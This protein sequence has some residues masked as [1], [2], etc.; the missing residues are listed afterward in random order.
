VSD[1]VALERVRTG[2]PYSLSVDELACRQIAI[3]RRAGGGIAYA[4]K[5]DHSNKNLA[6]AEILSLFKRRKWPKGLSIL[7]MPGINWTFELRLLSLREGNWHRH[8]SS[9]KRTHI[10]AVELDPAIYTAATLCMPRST[11]SPI[12]TFVNSPMW[13]AHSTGSNA[14]RRFHNCD[15]YSLMEHNAHK[16][17]AA[18]L[19]FLGPLSCQKMQK[20][21]TFYEQWIGSIFIVTFLAARH[22]Q[23]VT[24]DAELNDGLEG[25]LA[26]EL[27]GKILHCF[28]YQD[29]ASPM[30]Q[31]A[32][33][34]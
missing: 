28:R 11:D 1:H 10:C 22:E 20:I 33:Q 23:E 16:F 21:K 25:W 7:T 31:Y 5:I 32:V 30:L 19:D 26:K 18:W 29:G 6:R 4:R 15:M 2:N 13:T 3:G 8:A 24:L 9:T 17:D 14:I 12:V 27:P 34:K